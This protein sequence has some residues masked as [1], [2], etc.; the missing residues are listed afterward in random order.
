M[1]RIRLLSALTALLLPMASTAFAQDADEP[2]PSPEAG[3]VGSEMGGDTS[4]GGD[5][6]ATTSETSSTDSAAPSSGGEKPISVGLLLGYGI[7]LDLKGGPNPWGLGFGARGG[8]NIGQVYLGAR[9]VFYLGS[10]K[11]VFNGVS[12]ISYSVNLWELGI[13]GGYD[14]KASDALTIRPEFGLG[15]AG[16]SSDPG[17]SQTKL[18]IAPGASVLYDV[19]DTIFLGIDARFQLVFVDPDNVKAIIFLANGGMRF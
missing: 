12:T 5:V 18:F 19:T 4:A 14:V 11:D 2:A 17:T 3:D 8:Y 16:A 13:E 10:S 6:S 7:G 15:L 1:M 9:F